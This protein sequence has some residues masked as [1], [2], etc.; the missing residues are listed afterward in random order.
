MSSHQSNLTISSYNITNDTSYNDNKYG[1]TEPIKE[2]IEDIFFDVQK[3]KPSVIKRLERLC[4]KYPRVPQFKNYLAVSLS[5]AGNEKRAFEVNEQALKA[6]PD[7]LFARTNQAKVLMEKGKTDAIPELLG[8]EMELK[9]LYPDK[10]QFHILEVL[11]Y[12][13]TTVKYFLLV[14]DPHNA[15][16]R[17]DLLREIDAS[18]PE[19][20][21]ALA[22]MARYNMKKAGERIKRDKATER[23]VESR[24][25]NKSVQTEKKPDFNHSEIEALYEYGF[26]I[27][28]ERIDEILALPRESLI[29]DLETVLE[30]TIKRFEFFRNEA[31]ETGWKDRKYSFSIHAVY[32][33][34]EL[35]SENS[36]SYI[37]E[38][39]RQGDEFLD[40]WYADSL[41]PFF[42]EPVAVLAKN[43]L[44][45]LSEFVKEP[46]NSSYARN[47]ATTAVEHV[48]HFNQ[49]MKPAVINMF[50]DWFEF[51]LNRLDDDSIIDTQLLSFMVWSCINLN[52]DELLDYIRKL[53]ELNLIS[54]SMMGSYADIEED[55]LKIDF[56]RNEPS[57]IFKMYK[58]FDRSLDLPAG[59]DADYNPF[60]TPVPNINT[61]QFAEDDPWSDV[62]RNDP[63]PCGSG[64]KYKKCC[65]QK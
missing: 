61:A 42:T 24:S 59:P 41:E 22:D 35:N 49:E 62:G 10:D 65:L 29:Q 39:L 2:I 63:C 44:D 5:H 37:L 34:A 13:N 14:D 15:Q 28:P 64:R 27:S 3:G 55:I 47:I 6:H 4:K 58:E 12:F 11:T 18:A 48:A 60:E 8:E 26:D 17:L 33:L 45:E 51:H 21:D 32:L 7:Y 19:T 43:H 54:I 57:G 16:I 40:F 38:I 36:L 53:Y 56:K 52:A 50:R 23:R 20:F 46:N 31:E 30:D 25:Y 1:I 9:A